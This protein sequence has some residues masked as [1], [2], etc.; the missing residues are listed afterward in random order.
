MLPIKEFLASCYQ[1]LTSR[2]PVRASHASATRQG[3]S[4]ACSSLR[5][6]ATSRELP[7]TRSAIR[8]GS[9]HQELKTAY[10]W[11]ETGKADCVVVDALSSALRPPKGALSRRQHNLLPLLSHFQARGSSR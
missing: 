10:A 11:D 8:T 6:R 5:N 4:L 1:G 2:D 3:G 7:G 9:T